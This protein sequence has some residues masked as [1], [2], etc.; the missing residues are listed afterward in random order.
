MQQERRHLRVPV[1][2]G[3]GPKARKITPFIWWQPTDPANPAAGV[4]ERHRNIISGKHDAYIRA[5]AKAAK[6]HGRP[7]HR[8]HVP[9]DEQQLVPLGHR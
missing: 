5:W 1:G 9:R 6:A 7:G 4:Y 3:Q 8:A 2:G